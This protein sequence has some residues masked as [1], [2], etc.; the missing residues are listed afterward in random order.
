MLSLEFI[1]GSEIYKAE[2]HLG[3]DAED[4]QSQFNL[5]MLICL[6]TDLGTAG[7]SQST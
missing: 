6:T 2:C 5:K 3:G 7:G 1:P 4:T